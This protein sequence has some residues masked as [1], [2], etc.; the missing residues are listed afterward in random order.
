VSQRQTAR[1]GK[2]AQVALLCA[3]GSELKFESLQPFHASNYS[4]GSGGA[5]IAIIR[6][7]IEKQNNSHRTE[8]QNRTAS[9]SALLTLS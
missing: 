6:Q 2:A 5:P 3:I 1:P 8:T 7:Y 9:P 4:G